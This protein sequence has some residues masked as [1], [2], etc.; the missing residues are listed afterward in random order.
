M[1]VAGIVKVDQIDLAGRHAAAAVIAT[2]NA[3]LTARRKPR[4][5]ATIGIAGPAQA[6]KVQIEKTV[7][8]AGQ[9][10][11]ARRSRCHPRLED[12]SRRGGERTVTVAT[13]PHLK[14]A[15]IGAL[16]AE[17]PEDRGGE[18]PAQRSEEKIVVGSEEARREQEVKEMSAR[19]DSDDRNSPSK[20]HWCKDE[21]LRMLEAQG[22]TATTGRNGNEDDCSS[23][24]RAQAAAHGRHSFALGGQSSSVQ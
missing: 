8:R 24:I 18:G 13:V 15:K 11:V 12:S 1:A 10:E 17:G 4:S 7:N 22:A 14:T 6:L 20:S 5:S 3:A 2:E 9:A 19:S 23:I 16:A 21:I